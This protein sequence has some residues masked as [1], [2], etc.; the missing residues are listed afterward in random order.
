M[1]IVGLT[2]NIAAGKSTV[3]SALVSRGATLI[4]SDVAA[5][6]A[7]APG[8]PALSA[9]ARRFGADMLQADG[10]L[11][12][13]RLGQQVFA[14]IETRHA[15]ERILHPAIEAARQGALRAARQR[16]DAIVVCDI[17]LLFEARLAFQ[18]ARI[19]LVD[20][21]V[22]TRVARLQ[23]TR[24]MTAA[25]AEARVRA[26]LSAAVKRGR[27]D[28]V[29]DN[30]GDPDMLTAKIARAWSRLQDW[31]AGSAAIPLTQATSHD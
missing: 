22:G 14:D 23:Q 11:D 13:A 7:V 9:I 18:F 19:I 27:A 17:P 6:A 2:G 3:A 5:R 25:D 31:S 15:L 29:L 21:S 10:T 30:D 20:A 24:R 12:R 1:L 26:Q 28:L 4:D 16:G 8:S